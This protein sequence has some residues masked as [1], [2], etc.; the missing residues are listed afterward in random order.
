VPATA[1]GRR[2]GAKRIDYPTHRID[3]V[4][5]V[6]VVDGLQ[7]LVDLAAELD[8]LEWEQ[9]L[10]STLFHG[11]VTIP[12]IESALPDLSRARTKGVARMRRILALRPAGAPRRNPCSKR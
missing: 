6:P 2:T 1:S 10:E 4:E 9:S 7:M 11:L 3:Y 12:V 5:R 8:D